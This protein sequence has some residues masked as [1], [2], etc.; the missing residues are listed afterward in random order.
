MKADQVETL[1]D[2]LEVSKKEKS[3]LEDEITQLKE[4]I[5]KMKLSFQQELS[6]FQDD[7]RLEMEA[8]SIRS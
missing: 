7:H 8:Q 3:D 6:K 2:L 5:E 4:S 1:T